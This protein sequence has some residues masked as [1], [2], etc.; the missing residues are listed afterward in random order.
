[1]L[2]QRL[3]SAIGLSLT[4]WTIYHL[5][6]TL[7]VPVLSAIAVYAL[8]SLLLEVALKKR[9]PSREASLTTVVWSTVWTLIASGVLFGLFS[10]LT[11][12]FAYAGRAAMSN[13]W[14]WMLHMAGIVILFLAFLFVA[15]LHISLQEVSGKAKIQHWYDAPVMGYML[16]YNKGGSYLTAGTYTLLAVWAACLV[17][18]YSMNAYGSFFAFLLLLYCFGRLTSVRGV[19]KNGKSA[20]SAK[21][22]RSAKWLGL[23]LVFVFVMFYFLL[24]R[25]FIAVLSQLLV[26]VIIACIL[27]VIMLLCFGLI[28]L[29]LFVIV[30]WLMI[31]SIFPFF[32]AWVLFMWSFSHP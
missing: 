2:I 30:K 31:L 18:M 17:D 6:F 20:G 27:A 15:S 13:F 29:R 7:T 24:A 14:L 26:L 3:V 23:T 9:N 8:G 32:A 10:G 12:W 16:T 22:A 21:G 11:S 19:H 1:M 5:K 25:D 28:K 4:A